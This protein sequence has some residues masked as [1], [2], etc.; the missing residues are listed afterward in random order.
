MWNWYRYIGLR[1]GSM[2]D[3]FN[4]LFIICSQYDVVLTSVR[5]RF[6]VIYVVRTLKRCLVITGFFCILLVTGMGIHW[7][8]YPVKFVIEC[9]SL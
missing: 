3:V 6:N 8:S 4:Y 1:Y 5:R 9:R 2:S 7:R